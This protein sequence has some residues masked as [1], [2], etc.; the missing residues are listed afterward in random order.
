VR[1]EP[2]EDLTAL[3]SRTSKRLGLHTRTAIY[4]ELPPSQRFRGGE[5]VKIA[6]EGPY[7]AR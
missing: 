4:N 7:P 5:S 6:R 2:G 1:A 3:G